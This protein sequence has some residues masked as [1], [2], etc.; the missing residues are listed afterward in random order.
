MIFIVYFTSRHVT[1]GIARK[2][3]LAPR[4]VKSGAFAHG[5]LQSKPPTIVVEGAFHRGGHLAPSRAGTWQPGAVH[6]YEARG[7]RKNKVD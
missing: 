1:R 3:A 6:P 2:T 4:L 7:G 5:P